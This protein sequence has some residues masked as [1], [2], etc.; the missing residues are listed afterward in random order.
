MCY[1]P[2]TWHSVL[3][4]HCSSIQSAVI[5]QMNIDVNC[6]LQPLNVPRTKDQRLRG[7]ILD[8]VYRIKHYVSNYFLSFDSVFILDL[9]RQSIAHN[10]C[11]LIWSSMFNRH[12]MKTH[13]RIVLLL[14]LA[15]GAC[16]FCPYNGI[17]ENEISDC[18]VWL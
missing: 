9:R 16:K 11:S 13:T 1:L 10:V 14:L 4:A 15:M 7:Q 2:D 18:F 17:C 8:M 5:Y 12:S 6:E 3:I